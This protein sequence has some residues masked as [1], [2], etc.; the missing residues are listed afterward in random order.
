MQPIYKVIKLKPDPASYRGIYLSSTIAK[1][2]EST[3]IKRLTK[4]I[5]QH[6]TLRDNQL[7]FLV[8]IFFWFVP[9]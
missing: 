6:S 5:E 1:L 3:T 9:Y 8:S 4:Y 7:G 2:F